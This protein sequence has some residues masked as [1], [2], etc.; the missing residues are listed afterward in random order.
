MKPLCTSLQ[1]TTAHCSLRILFFHLDN[2]RG[3]CMMEDSQLAGLEGQVESLFQHLIFMFSNI[4]PN[5]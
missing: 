1:S 2:L 4:S 5:I 3:Q